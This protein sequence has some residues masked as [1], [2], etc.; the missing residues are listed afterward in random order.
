MKV[1]VLSKSLPNRWAVFLL[2]A[3]TLVTMVLFHP[4][5]ARC[6][7]AVAVRES[8]GDTLQIE[9]AATP[10]NEKPNP[11]NNAPPQLGETHLTYSNA[12]PL[13]PNYFRT[14]LELVAV[15][16]LAEAWYYATI[17]APE[18]YWYNNLAEYLRGRFVTG[19][20]YCLD[21][22]KWETNIGHAYA[23][24]G[25]Y[26]IARSN[27]LS[28][29]ASF[30]FTFGTSAAWEMFGEPREEFSINDMIVTP[31]AGL[32]IGEVMYQ[33]GE[34][35][36]HS[37][38]TIF[39]RVMGY[40][41]DPAIA[42]HRWIDNDIPKPPAKTDKFG[43][44][45]DA[46]HRFRL[47][48]G[49]GG[50]YSPEADKA[51]TEMLFGADMEV[52]T[53]EKYSRPGEASLWYKGGTFNELTFSVALDGT[54]I[55]DFQFFAKSAYL[56]H[57]QQNIF[58]PVNSEKIEGTSL[59]YGL[60]S[61]FEYYTHKY[62]GYEREDRLAICDLVGPSLIYDYYHSRFHM[63]TAVDFYPTFSMV[64]A[65]AGEIYDETHDLQG[66]TGVYG[67]QQYYYAMGFGALGKMEM[68]YG[69]LG[70]E[71]IIR[72]HYFS[73]IQGMDRTQD[74]VTHELDFEDQNLRLQFSVY[75]ALPGENLK[76]AFDAE[77]IYRWSDI[78]AFNRSM[79]ETRFFA[80]M[81]Y[82]F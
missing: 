49:G 17:T 25:Y 54:D 63:R 7:S 22:N 32:P 39:N 46:W 82:E 10:S 26:L 43:F 58:K 81:V 28:V 64:Q 4:C 48:S 21:V 14:T 29:G 78:D 70:L 8:S 11:E 31:F 3:Y 79:D 74:M 36:Q 69:P 44:T 53:A 9:D 2:A 51:R 80:R 33:L 15:F 56:G 6:G 30:L 55:P 60:S 65:A 23:G 27:D 38:D 18:W 34:F 24:T 47:Y 40:L 37:S 59:Y 52:V 19:D 75:W 12:Y 71:G 61:A 57:Y 50:T 73:G 1:T 72:Y 68:E 41:F 20:A 35:F 62:I 13:T 76:V 77:K 42:I 16:G 67:E 45:T 66:V 5:Q